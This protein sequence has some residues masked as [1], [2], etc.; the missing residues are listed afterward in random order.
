LIDVYLYT[1]FLH[2]PDERRSRQFRAC[3]K[4]AGGRPDLLMWLFLSALL[5]CSA[6]YRNAGNVIA[7]FFKGHCQY[8]KSS[9]R[10]LS[11]ISNDHSGLGVLEK[12]ETQR[13]KIFREQVGALAKDLWEKSGTPAGGPSQFLAEALE[14]LKQYFAEQ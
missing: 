12:K 14:H 10:V 13:Q 11:T 1:K 9:P 2:Q 7:Q 8:K 4:D 3:L 5:Q 6:H